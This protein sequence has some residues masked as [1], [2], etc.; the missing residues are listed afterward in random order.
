[1]METR[2]VLLGGTLGDIILAVIFIDLPLLVRGSLVSRV[3]SL[4]DLLRPFRETGTIPKRG[5]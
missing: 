5:M 2:F 1:M 4:F 3:R